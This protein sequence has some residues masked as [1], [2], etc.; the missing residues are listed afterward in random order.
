M[1]RWGTATSALLV[2]VLNV[3]LNWPLFEHGELPF[4]GS[5]E[6]GYAGMA[7]FV[8]GHPNPWGWNP[9]TYCGLPTQFMYPPL[10]L[11][12][13]GAAMR[14]LPHA[15]PQWIWRVIVSAATC[16]GPVTLFFFALYFT[17]SRRWAFAAAVAYSL[18]ST[19]YGLFPAV[20]K[21]RGIVQLPWRVQVLAKYG[22]GP[23]NTGLTLLPLALLA[24][25]RYAEKPAGDP[26][27]ARRRLLGAAV[28]LAAIPLVNWVAAFALAASC[29]LLLVA[30]WD[31]P[32]FGVRR[33][34]AAA[35]LAYLLACFW[36]TPSCVRTIA[37]NWPVDSFAYHLRTRQVWLIG[38]MIVGVVVIR[39][40]FRLLHGSLYFCFVTLAAFVFGWIA[41]AWYLYGVDT[42]PESRRYAIEFEFFLMLALFEAFRLA[43]ASGNS[44]VRISAWGTAGVMLLVGLPQLWAYTTQGWDKWSPV[45]AD[46]TVEYQLA[47]WLN[48]HKPRGRVFA[49]GGLKF[50]LNTWFDI[51]QV[52]GGFETGLQN[53]TP[54]D[55]A[56]RIR[57]G[58]ED[59]LPDLQ[60]MDV[61]Y[62]V[63]HGPDSREY[64]RDFKNPER[65]SRF[66]AVFHIEDDTIYEVPERPSPAKWLDNNTLAVSGSGV[67]TLPVNADPGWGPGRDERGFLRVQ[68]P[69]MLHY[70]GTA[71]QR[72]MAA[73]S[74][75]AW[76]ASLAAV[77]RYRRTRKP[78]HPTTAP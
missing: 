48:D 12:A 59:P 74:A 25:W 35:G 1:K 47:K 62:V 11:Y 51:Q 49:S 69:A 17:R 57:A 40:A 3:L 14:A 10:L 33:A 21:D 75:L 58:E 76:S 32:E 53:R 19:S 7:R 29:A 61:Q 52:G 68:A 30:G 9:F 41:T 20:E 67:A 78:S 13:A 71:E 70:H 28:L 27:V 60:A 56:Y 45:P 50:R 15:E 8:S 39:V 46:T 26:H 44:T 36:L 42:V 73:L 72:L 2:L 23:H 6:G 24:L 77:F 65:L 63:V 37:F 54:V 4:R 66:P 31:Q 16:L 55:M 64:Y 34:F 18:F 5:I 22:E 38:G 43:L